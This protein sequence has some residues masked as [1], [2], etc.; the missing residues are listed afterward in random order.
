MDDLAQLVQKQAALAA[1][2]TSADGAVEVTVDSQRMVTKVVVDDGYL[3]DYELSELGDHVTRAAQA[4][5]AEVQRRASE[6]FTPVQDRRKSISALSGMLTD[7]PDFT[8]AMSLF[9]S[10]A[11]SQFRPTT[12][13]S[14]NDPNDTPDDGPISTIKL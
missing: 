5:A 7:A 6:L 1:K 11:E 12:E 3:D 4:A 2:A 10:L 13:N 8:D 14:E 9:S